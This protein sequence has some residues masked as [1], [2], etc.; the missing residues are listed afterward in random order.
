MDQARIGKLIAKLRKKKG[1]TQSQLGEMVGVGDRA[2]SKW[3]RG[4]TLPNIAII[5]QL[6]EILGISSNELL[7]GK[8]KIST[9]GKNLTI[10]SRTK[11]YLLTIIPVILIIATI[12]IAFSNKQKVYVLKADSEEYNVVGRVVFSNNTVYI[13]IDEI[14]CSNDNIKNIKIV[15]YEYRLRS[16]KTLLFRSG[17]M[18][19]YKKKINSI[20]IKDV[21]SSLKINVNEKDVIDRK[22][23]INQGMTLHFTFLTDNNSTINEELKINLIPEKK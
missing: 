17:Y 10:S 14:I 4:I 20:T 9:K 8:E 1:L 12:I 3:E 16:S 23:I 5:N 15:N 19:E 6:S 18:S 22:K 7:S 21:L 13:S 2:V 11:R